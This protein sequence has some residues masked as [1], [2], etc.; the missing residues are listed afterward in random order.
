MVQLGSRSALRWQ[1]G[2]QHQVKGLGR[3]TA[4]PQKVPG[5]GWGLAG[6]AGG[7]LCLFHAGNCP[8]NCSLV[9]K[10]EEKEEKS[11]FLLKQ[12]ENLEKA[13]VEGTAE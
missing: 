12:R 10:Q 6:R 3:A 9:C 8:Q 7:S 11:S 2:H 13:Q 1:Q 5:Q 4:G